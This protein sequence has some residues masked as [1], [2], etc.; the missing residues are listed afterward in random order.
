[1]RKEATMSDDP[2]AK[3]DSAEAWTDFC[4]LL[5]KA[6]DV[7]LRDDLARSTFDRAEGHRYLLRLLRGG[8]QA[9]GEKTDPRYPIFRAMPALVKMGLD[10]PDNY[11]L[12]TAVDPEL[13]YRIR[14]T[15][16]TICYMSFAAQ[17]QNFAARDRI[18]GGAGH[19]NDSEL[20]LGPDGSFEILASQQEQPGNWLRMAPDTTQILLRQTFLDRSREEP[21]KVE[22]ECLDAEGAPPPLSAERVPGMLMG[23]AMYAIGCA[24]WFAD[25]V[26]AMR[27]K[28]PVNRFHLPD[29]ENHRLVGGDPNVRLW[30]GTWELAPDEA[31]V[32][33]ATPPRCDYWNFQLANI[34]AESLDYE[35]RRVHINSGQARLREDGS[36][37]LVVAHRDPGHPNWIDTAGHDHGTMGVRWVRAEAHPEPMCR[38]VKLAELER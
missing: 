34:W 8:S 2:K 3:V 27:D 5:K 38:V 29:A 14:G 28:A 20:A 13:T 30:L 9:F 24:S 35:F 19:L 23:S 33:E 15:R 26:V 22:V 16:G 18:S 31:L 6:G 12:G 7:L 4:E 1:M 21:V 32:I 11:Y 10:N 36:F 17:N 25:W 37:Q